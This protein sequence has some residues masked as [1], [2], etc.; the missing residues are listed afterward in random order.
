MPQHRDGG[1]ALFLEIAMLHGK[2]QI[3][4]KSHIVCHH[5]RLMPVVDE[6]LQQRQ[7]RGLR[8]SASRV[9]V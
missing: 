5:H 1:C 3:L 4:L 6:K 8:N 7:L 9:A 2:V